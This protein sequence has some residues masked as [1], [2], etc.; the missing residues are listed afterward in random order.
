MDLR[1]CVGHGCLRITLLGV[2]ESYTFTSTSTNNPL[3][4]ERSRTRKCSFF[5]CDTLAA[6][7][8]RR[9]SSRSLLIGDK[10]L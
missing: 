4:A 1:H 9:R 10:E 7:L 2:N 8:G 3:G 5:I 6:K